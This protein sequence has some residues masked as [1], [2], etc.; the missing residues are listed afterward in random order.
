MVDVVI[1]TP[2]KDKTNDGR[3]QRRGTT[4]RAAIRCGA[5]LIFAFDA[6]QDLL[7][8]VTRLDRHKAPFRNTTIARYR[9]QPF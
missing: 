5:V 6:V 9:R 4:T 3:P 1:K 7:L 8:P 2:R